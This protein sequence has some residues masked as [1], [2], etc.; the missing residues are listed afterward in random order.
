MVVAEGLL[1]LLGKYAFTHGVIG[2]VNSITK[3]WA[4]GVLFRVHFIGV[5]SNGG[6]FLFDKSDNRP[7]G[8]VF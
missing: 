6:Y 3:K 4:R 7:V 8:S 1:L 2:L 5:S